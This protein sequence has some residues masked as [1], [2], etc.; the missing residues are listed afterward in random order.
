MGSRTTVVRV[1]KGYEMG[2]IH[3]VSSHVKARATTKSLITLFQS[4]NGRRSRY[5]GAAP[6]ALSSGSGR[7]SAD[8]GAWPS[9]RRTTSFSS[10]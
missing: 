2:G 8:T 9:G 7:R 1:G 6:C 3:K 10:T 4:Q 5:V